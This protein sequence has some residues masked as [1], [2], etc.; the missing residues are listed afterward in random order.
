M[1]YS[2]PLAEGTK[3]ITQLNPSIHPPPLGTLLCPCNAISPLPLRRSVHTTALKYKGLFLPFML[4]QFT[5]HTSAA[6][7]GSDTATGVDLSHSSL[8]LCLYEPSRTRFR[9]SSPHYFCKDK[10][11][12]TRLLRLNI[13]KILYQIL[14]SWLIARGNKYVFVA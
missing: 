12:C 6:Q 13:A 8:C 14:L 7:C 11:I 3:P 5:L 10:I 4:R 1:I 2:P 9:S